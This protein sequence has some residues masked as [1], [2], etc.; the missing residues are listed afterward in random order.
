MKAEVIRETFGAHDW[1]WANV[2]W[3]LLEAV[4]L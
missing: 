1:S 4:A 2:L 3:A